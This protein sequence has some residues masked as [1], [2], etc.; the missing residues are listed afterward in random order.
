MELL[1][2]FLRL[3]KIVWVIAPL[4]ALFLEVFIQVKT[5]TVLFDF[6]IFDSKVDGWRRQESY[7]GA[8]G[9]A[10]VSHKLDGW[11]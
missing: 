6:L 1:R 4:F 3:V 9:F 10:L 8:M 5:D 2:N 11:L 7:P